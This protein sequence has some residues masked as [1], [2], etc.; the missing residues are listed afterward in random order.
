MQVACLVSNRIVVFL[1]FLRTKL[2]GNM[3][4]IIVLYI[5]GHNSRGSGLKQCHM[6]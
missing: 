2:G 6:T 5:T 4:Q 1:L 3:L